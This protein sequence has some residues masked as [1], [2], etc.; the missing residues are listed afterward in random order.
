MANDAFIKKS[1]MGSVFR[2]PENGKYAGYAYFI[3]ND[4]IKSSRQLVDLQSDSRE[5]CYELSVRKD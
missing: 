5:L 3:F 2:M 1:N 4:K